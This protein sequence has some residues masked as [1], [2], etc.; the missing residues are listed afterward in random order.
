[1]N[2][3]NTFVGDPAFFDRDLARYQVVTPDSMKTV[4]RQHLE[5]Q[6]HVSLSI[7]PRGRMNLAIPDS[8]PAVVS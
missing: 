5:H 6:R 7:V 3:Y 2:A 4:V 1:L 8:T